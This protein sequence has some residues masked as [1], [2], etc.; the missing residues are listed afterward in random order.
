M[1]H[2]LVDW[3]FARTLP[4]WREHG[5]DSEAGGFYERLDAARTPITDDAKRAMVQ[6]RQ[7]FTFCRAAAVT[8]QP[9]MIAPAQSGFAFL[10][11]HYGHPDGGWRFSVARD[12]TPADDRRDLYTHAFV[13]LSLAAYYETT[14]AAKAQTLAEETF[15]FIRD[16]MKHPK[17]GYYEALD[18]AGAATDGPRRQNPHMHLLEAF[19]D[20]FAV[21]GNSP[22]LDRARSI[23]TLFHDRFF[24][25]GSLREYFDDALRPA[26]GDA[27]RL[28]EPGHHFE[29]VWLLDRYRTLAGDRTVADT[30]T[31]LYR[32]AVSHGLDP[33]SGATVDAVDCAGRP[34]RTGRRIWP[35]TEAIKAHLVAIR[36]A[37]D[38]A[39][40]EYL[41]RQADALIDGHLKSLPIG[42]WRE[43]L[44]AG[45]APCR[46]DL[47]ASSLYHLCLAAAEL[48][49]AG[50]RMTPFAAPSGAIKCRA[51]PDHG[52]RHAS[53]TDR[54]S[55]YPGRRTGG[56]PRGPSRR[57]GRR[58]KAGARI[59]RG[60][61]PGRRRR[62]RRARPADI[63]RFEIPRYSE[64]R[65]R[66]G[67]RGD[68]VGAGNPERPCRRR[69]RDDDGGA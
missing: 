67:A 60:E 64:H 61:R 55:R 12:G 42:A 50:R 38:A 1:P 23:I 53:T 59:L 57:C 49:R 37:D 2:R 5:V 40:E 24:V 56:R 51:P 63:S 16:A 28:V 45:G 46:D 22:W 31:A 48:R 35:Q 54:C 65:C 9:A 27:G 3:V 34:V 36:E 58:H 19:L 43:H 13:L 26:A 6:A 17:G 41:R 47:P 10:V 66:R 14:R 32:F 69:R 20:W 25:D 62:R 8:G 68:A 44:T 30:V 21:T 18:G 33:E 11:D 52:H 39:A 15:S 7:I 29:W 4:Y